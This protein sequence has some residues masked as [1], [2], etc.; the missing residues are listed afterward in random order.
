MV[1][2][3]GAGGGGCK[4]VWQKKKSGEKGSNFEGHQVSWCPGMLPG[5]V[6]K[7]LKVPRTRI[8]HDG[9]SEPSGF[10]NLPKSARSTAVYSLFLW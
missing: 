3:D 5:L 6:R 4:R 2:V 8:Q 9:P 10:S 1:V 7:D